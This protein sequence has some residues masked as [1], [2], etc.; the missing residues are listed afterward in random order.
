MVQVTG[1]SPS[2]QSARPANLKG[3]G[4]VNND[5]SYKDKFNKLSEQVQHQ[6][7]YLQAV[8][9]ALAKNQVPGGKEDA[10]VNAQT[11]M[12]MVTTGAKFEMDKMTFET[13]L[14][15][16]E[17]M[18]DCAIA[19]SS[20]MVGR[21]VSVDD[22]T[23]AFSGSMVKF[24]YSI[25]GTKPEN[26]VLQA[27]ITILDDHG[28][29]VFKK[30]IKNPSIG[31]NIF[32]W[33]G[34]DDESNKVPN[35]EY[36]IDIEAS[37]HLPGEIPIPM[38]ADAVKEGEVEAVEFDDKKKAYFIIDGQRVDSRSLR[39]FSDHGVKSAQQSFGNADNHKSYIGETV[40]IKQEKI[41][42]NGDTVDV[43]V[44]S[45]KDIPKATLRVN[46][47]D[48][49]DRLIAVD[50]TKDA[51]VKV[52][53][54]I[55]S[56]RGLNS[57]KTSEI[58]SMKDNKLTPTYVPYGTYRYEVSIISD[59]AG[60]EVV[61]KLDNAGTY[62]IQAI[63]KVD[64]KM[65]LVDT[66]GHKFSVD[67]VVRTERPVSVKSHASLI[68]EANM[69]IDKTIAFA[70]N[71]IRYEGKDVTRM[72]GI[73]A[74]TDDALKLNNATLHIYDAKTGA[75]VRNITRLDSDVYSSTVNPVPVFDDLDDNSQDIII[76][77]SQKMY[78]KIYTMITDPLQKAN[79][80]NAIEQRFR[81]GRLFTS[82]SNYGNP[83]SGFSAELKEDIKNRNQGIMPFVWD[84]KND[85][86][87][88][89]PQGEYKITM[90]YN[91]VQ[92]ANG[93]I[94]NSN[95]ELS[96]SS[97]AQV[98]GAYIASGKVILMLANGATFEDLDKIN[99]IGV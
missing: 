79:L 4:P 90:T 91:E 87:D 70:T 95:K 57:T 97:S 56:W 69:Y 61:T 5:N 9:F 94:V 42:F 37:Y 64:G 20:E 62:K 34:K 23:R 46:F 86:G 8:L 39:K 15:V 16:A 2:A 67:D 77:I 84:G 11:V 88:L 98:V 41:T 33:D 71:T 59:D 66:N 7:E 65:M 21:R 82:A 58:Q 30:T 43:S 74:P 35:G 76:E 22:S 18:R 68:E 72:I 10:G 60:K 40:S 49:K 83:V 81:G 17:V 51:D 45:T 52:G 54:N 1:S 14:E 78:G 93:D 6:K 12:G 44:I 92:S 53:Q 19:A 96:L 55:I 99:Y 47:Y 89:M 32:E 38:N 28:N 36:K 26:A 63:E 3:Q 27:E 75:L 13:M 25:Y 24:D 31:K 50:E 29:R 85:S 73:P 80:D 48:S